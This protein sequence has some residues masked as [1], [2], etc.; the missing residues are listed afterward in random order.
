MAIRGVRGANVVPVDQ[1]EM[2][3]TATLDLLQAIQITRS[4]FNTDN[5]GY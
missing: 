1:P 2:I 4:L 5:I 3:Y